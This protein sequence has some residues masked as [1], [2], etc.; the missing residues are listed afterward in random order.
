MPTSTRPRRPGS[1]SGAG[2]GTV[3]WG[4]WRCDAAASFSTVW[5]AELPGSHRLA[6]LSPVTARVMRCFI[7]VRSWGLQR[8]C[9]ADGCAGQLYP[10]RWCRR[11]TGWP[12]RWLESVRAGGH[13]P[14]R[15]Q[16]A[17]TIRSG[18]VPTNSPPPQ[19]MTSGRS[20]TSRIT[21]KGLC[22][23]SPSSWMPPE[24]VSSRLAVSMISTMGG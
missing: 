4:P 22:K 2:A 1:K 21:S 10:H 7:V 12:G 6:A 18:S 20:V 8:G 23:D 15:W 14:E 24:S 9:H 19:V 5:A 17:G 11:Q 16:R 13:W 3:S